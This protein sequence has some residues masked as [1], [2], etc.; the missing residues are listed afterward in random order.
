MEKLSDSAKSIIKEEVDIHIKE[1]KLTI[2]ILNTYKWIFGILL[3][4]LGIGTFVGLDYMIDEKVD[5]RF[6]IYLEFVNAQSYM[7]SSSD[8]E[9]AYEK[10]QD[11]WPKLIDEKMVSQELRKIYYKNMI[12][13]L[14]NLIL[15]DNLKKEFTGQQTWN[16]LIKDDEFLKYLEKHSDDYYF[17]IYKVLCEIKFGNPDRIKRNLNLIKALSSGSDS[18]FSIHSG[19]EIYDR[20][21]YALCTSLILDDR[22]SATQYK[23]KLLEMQYF[24]F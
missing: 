24:F 8:Y 7:Y 19:D 1:F 16:Q 18:K 10:I 11:A 23:A 22:L 9:T 13:I 17:D 12:T 4:I 2:F 14:S 5:R 15:Y 3:T 20:Q 6:N 21:W